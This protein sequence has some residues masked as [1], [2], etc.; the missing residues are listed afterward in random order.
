MKLTIIVL[1]FFVL[2]S[3]G[4]GGGS[5][6][7]Q[8]SNATLTGMWM[9]KITNPVTVSV[10][11]KFDGNGLVVEDYDLNPGTLPYPYS[12]Q[13]NGTF[14]LFMGGPST[15]A[16]GMLT[17]ST[18]GSIT[19][20]DGFPVTATLK[21]ILNLGACQG[22]WAGTLA[23][24]FAS[25]FSIT[26]DNTGTITGGSGFTG[27]IG[28]KL[29][30]QSSDATGLVTTGEVSPLSRFKFFTGTVISGATV[31]I[32]GDYETNGPGGTYTL[33]K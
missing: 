19:T 2:V 32:S 25:S 33:V 11:Y 14:T 15:S 27:P 18:E 28:G 24:G 6:G 4:G 22:T 8:Y 26:V 16:S 29:F 7:P 5:G 17:S 12:V 31:T 10:A 30:C 20:S 1:M 9:I 21:K 3:C 13:A 23:G